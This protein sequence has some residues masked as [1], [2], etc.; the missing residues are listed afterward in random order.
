M[1]NNSP[2]IYVIDKVMN[3]SANNEIAGNITPG[4]NVFHTTY[5]PTQGWKAQSQKKGGE[6]TKKEMKD[7]TGDT[8][9]Q[10]KRKDEETK[11]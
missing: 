6:N 10:G 2:Y 11:H 7:K 5:L 8:L 9:K 3:I 1:K 4:H